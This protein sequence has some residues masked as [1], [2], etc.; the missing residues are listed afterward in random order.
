VRLQVGGLV[1]D[2]RV[3]GAV[4]FIKTIFSKFIAQFKNLCGVA[5]G[6]IFAFIIFFISITIKIIFI[7]FFFFSL[8]TL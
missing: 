8:S 3:G 1:G 6:N 5:R 7:F 4:G 2:E